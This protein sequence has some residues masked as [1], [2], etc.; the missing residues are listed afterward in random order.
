M[1]RVLDIRSTTAMRWWTSATI[2]NAGV[3]KARALTRRRAP[4]GKGS[5]RPSGTPPSRLF[6]TLGGIRVPIGPTIRE[7]KN[8]ADER[9][10][11]GKREHL[12]HG[13]GD[14]E[15]GL[16][17]RD[18][19][20][21]R[22]RSVPPQDSRLPSRV[23]V[24]PTFDRGVTGPCWVAHAHRALARVGSR[25]LTEVQLTFA[26]VLIRITAKPQRPARFTAS[27]CKVDTYGPSRGLCLKSHLFAQ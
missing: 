8:V 4:L 12:D 2:Q 3:M 18:S 26:V 10:L 25:N 22:L 13:A 21:Q 14:S 5:S 9:H 16:P 6:R 24:L 1:L 19:S 23:A 15:A 20:R 27:R 17:G 11:L 7:G